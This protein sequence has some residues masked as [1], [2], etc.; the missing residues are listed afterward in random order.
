MVRL[1]RGFCFRVAFG[2][3]LVRTAVFIDGAYLDKI[4]ERNYGATR[5]AYDRLSTHLARGQD[6]LRTYYI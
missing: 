2:R 3:L 5:V 4:L 1:V 6:L